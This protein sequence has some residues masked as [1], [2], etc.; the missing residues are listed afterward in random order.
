VNQHAETEISSRLQ[1]LD[2]TEYDRALV[3]AMKRPVERNI[4][5]MLDRF[6]AHV[7]EFEK[8]RRMFPNEAVMQHARSAQRAH[9]LEFVFEARL[10]QEYAERV[11]RI[12]AAHVRIGL[13]PQWYLGGYLLV[14]NL[15]VELCRKRYRF[16]PRR[17]H[18]TI[19][20]IQKVVFLD[21]DLAITAYQRLRD[22]SAL[23]MAHNIVEVSEQ[24]STDTSG[25][26]ANVQELSANMEEIAGR[27]G[28]NSEN[29]QTTQKIASENSERASTGLSAVRETVDAMRRISEQ[30][31]TIEGIARNTNMLALNAAIEAARAGEAGKGFGVVATEVARLAE[32]TRNAAGQ[33]VELAENSTATAERA[34]ASIEEIVAEIE[35]TAELVSEIADGS[36][37]QRNGAES[38]KR[39][40]ANL[41]GTIQNSAGIA[42]KLAGL[43]KEMASGGWDK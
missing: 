40:L 11:V 13:T 10:D 3:R 29:A 42:E 23:E 27:I 41:D 35:K 26:A 19:R 18:H 9:W 12:G 32:H 43:A 6:Y 20:A 21:I 30:I 36:V 16:R 22:E 7:M 4:D 1:F 5:R 28:K 38:I 17:M 39:A 37:E 2:V 34:G 8:T 33:I 25:Q 31:D 15:L 24:L 14:L